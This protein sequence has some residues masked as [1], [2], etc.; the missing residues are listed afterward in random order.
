MDYL[1]LITTRFVRDRLRETSWADRWYIEDLYHIERFVKQGGVKSVMQGYRRQALMLH[2]PVE[3]ECISR[4]ITT[5]EVTSPQEFAQLLREHKE[6]EAAEK[7]ARLRVRLEGREAYDRAH[8]D[9]WLQM[10]GRP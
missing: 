8:R 1:K 9:L 7:Q 3:W 6:R 2:H 4:E 10:G 5:G